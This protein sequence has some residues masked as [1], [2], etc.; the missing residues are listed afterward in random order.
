MNC[1]FKSLSWHRTISTAPLIMPWCIKHT[2]ESTILPA[3]CLPKWHTDSF[4]FGTYHWTS[5][6]VFAILKFQ[7][8]HH[9]LKIVES[10]TCSPCSV[11]ITKHTRE[12]EVICTYW[13]FLKNKT[14][15]KTSPVFECWVPAPFSLWGSNI[16][17][18]SLLRKTQVS[19][20]AIVRFKFIKVTSQ[21]G[22][23]DGVRGVY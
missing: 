6:K 12:K 19:K 2:T 5:S 8:P 22:P 10:S 1:I 15:T 13:G 3:T 9:Q 18:P 16:R 21:K 4:H 14:K 23:L 20:S 11:F 17:I 7:L